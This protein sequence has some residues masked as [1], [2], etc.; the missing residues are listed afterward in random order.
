MSKKLFGKFFVFLLVAGLLFAVAPTRQALAQTPTT[1]NV[2]KWDNTHT[3]LPAGGR[4][5]VLYVEGV[6]H[7]WYGKDAT[8]ELYYMTSASPSF[9]DAESK[10]IVFKDEKS[11][12]KSTSV[13]VVPGGN[14]DFYMITYGDTTKEFAVY[15]SVDGIE[16]IRSAVVFDAGKIEEF[17]KIDAPF[18]LKDGEEYKLYFQVK[19][20]DGTYNIYLARTENLVKKP[21][22]LVQQKPVLTPDGDE[23]RVHH[24]TVVK[25]GSQYYMWY[26]TQDQLGLGVAKSLDGITWV[27]SLGNPIYNDYI[28]EPSVVKVENTWYVWFMSNPGEGEIFYLSSK[29]PF[30]FQTIQCAIDAA[31]NG[32]TIV[33][34]PGEFAEDVVVNDKYFNLIGA[35]NGVDGPT[36]LVGS[37]SIDNTGGDPGSTLLKNIY[38]KGD[39]SHLL[40]LKSVKNAQI[41]NCLFDGVGRFGTAPNL[42]GINLVSGGDGNSVI[43]VQDSIFRNGLYV[44]IGGYANDVTVTG[45]D[46]TNVKSGINLQGGGNLVVTDSTFLTKP[47]S[48]GD[49]Y[50]IRFASSSGSTPNLTVTGS[51]FTIDDSLGFDPTPTDYH[52]TI[53]IRAGAT[54]TI[55]IS[56]N[57]INN[58]LVGLATVADLNAI[59]AANV[60][61][62]GYGVYGTKI[63]AAPIKIYL[64][65]IYR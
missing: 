45:S 20:T 38:F 62:F 7:L 64:P 65:L 32:D 51:T 56:G 19:D 50:G 47:V 25:D 18:L 35:V 13:T 49:S 22:E 29:L 55:A 15:F 6:Y 1:L 48:D 9:K 39:D 16:W 27:K 14:K 61:P 33:V 17:E 36:W 52:A 8:N 23:T 12:I 57:T 60:F 53:I 28:A 31:K 46:F 5:S 44:G 54:G 63:T 30:E 58:E 10:K 41:Q 24:P 21:F 2:A 43:T 11:P 34:G 26:V 59:Y 4:P 37:M 3:S 42:N 40:I